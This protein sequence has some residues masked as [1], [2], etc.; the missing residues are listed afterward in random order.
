MKQNIIF[1]FPFTSLCVILIFILSFFSPPHTAL[2]NVAYIDKWTHLVMYGG[3]TA[4]FWLEYWYAD[5]RRSY[6]LGNVAL[7]TITLVI[8]TLLG[9]L[10]E[11]LQ[12]YCTG[13]RRSGDW[14]D[15]IA[16]TLGVVIAYLMGVTI[17]KQ[18]SLKIWKKS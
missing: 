2:D 16:D 14:F 3:T 10:I 6:R 13:G 17:L 1:L 12:A 7:I 9:G 15:W 8:P 5:I 18:L 11:L 4:V